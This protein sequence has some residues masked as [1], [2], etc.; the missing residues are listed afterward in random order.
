MTGGRIKKLKKYLGNESFFAT[1][2]D[3]ISDIN[4][5]KLLKFHK[6]NKKLV[7][8]TA[9]RPPARFEQL[10]YQEIKLNFLRKKIK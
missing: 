6:Q 1:Y 2:G 7:T 3:G 8:L 4:L 10:N 9:V 5:N